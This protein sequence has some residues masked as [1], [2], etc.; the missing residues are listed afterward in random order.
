MENYKKGFIEFLVKS[1]AL[2][3]GEF[4][5]K[6]GRV[7]PYFINTGMFKDGDGI[8]K[9]ASYYAQAIKKEFGENFDVLY[10][11]AYKGIP[12]CVSTIIELSR[13]GIN[14]GYSFNRKEAKD[15][16][17]GGQIV[18]AALDE[19]KEIV[20]ID[21]VITAGTA[22]KETIDVLKKNGNP[23]I[24]GI[25]ISVNR[26]EKGIGEKSAIQ[27]LQETLGVR[28]LS[29]IDFDEITNY[30]HNREIDGKIYLD[31]NL[32]SQMIEYKQKYGV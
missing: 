24:K 13:L 25:I 32:H 9:L 7:S 11:P 18:G 1:G 28:I 14:K 6:S 2:K 15:H 5:L 16:G 4:T 21:D 10:G 20:I 3:F 31:D 17:E 12:L 8:T 27:E 26:K 30:L 19:N 22:V 23:K 29:I